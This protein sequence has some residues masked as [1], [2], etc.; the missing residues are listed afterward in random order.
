LG[1][2][3]WIREPDKVKNNANKKGAGEGTSLLLRKGGGFVLLP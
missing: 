1:I 2:V 3:D